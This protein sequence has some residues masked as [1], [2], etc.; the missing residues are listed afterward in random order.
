MNLVS[1]FVAIAPNHISNFENIIE[2]DKDIRFTVLLNPG[3]F[4]FK[5]A[6]WNQVIE[7]DLNLRYTESSKF[8]KLKYQLGKLI[9]YKSFIAQVKKHLPKA[10]QYRYYY[11]NLDDI[12][13]NHIFYYFDGKDITIDNYVVE[14]GIL[15]YYYPKTNNKKLKLKKV[16]CKY[17]LGVDIIPENN[18]PTGI[19]LDKVNAQ[20][21]RLPEK[22]IFPEKSN[23]LPFV[24]INYEPV[25][26][27]ILVV[28][29]DIMHNSDEGSNYYK[30]KLKELFGHILKRME[31]DCKI[32]YKPHRNG[33]YTIAE[34]ILEVTFTNFELYLDIT[35]IEECLT[36]I[37]P[38][39]I[40]SFNSSALINLKLA[41]ERKDIYIAGLP[42]NKNSELTSLF[43][44]I[45]IEILS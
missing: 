24:K 14:D 32:I 31:R 37:K 25:K 38:A 10:Q 13:T 36:Q 7:G 1:I 39:Y 27:I 40:Y 34:E 20:Y 6:V 45:G 44:S 12:L 3:N 4:K 43:N 15:N 9:G 41:L 30:K 28:G 22:S 2:S 18:H 11:C 5:P 29:Q 23:Q 26:N 8:N 19:H 42:Y 35:P 21:V 16:L 33:D 17:L